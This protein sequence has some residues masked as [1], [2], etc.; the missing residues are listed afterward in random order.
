MGNN[1]LPPYEKE[2]CHSCTRRDA[3]TKSD[4]EGHG[5]TVIEVTTVTKTTRKKHRVTENKAISF[6]KPMSTTLIVFG[7]E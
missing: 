4:N 3:E 1:S 5:T 6:R 2:T 7:Y